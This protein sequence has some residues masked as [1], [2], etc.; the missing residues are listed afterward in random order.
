MTQSKNYLFLI[1]YYRAVG[2]YSNVNNMNIMKNRQPNLAKTVDTDKGTAS[3]RT[4]GPDFKFRNHD[5]SPTFHNQPHE[6][7]EKFETQ[8][9]TKAEREKAAGL[10]WIGDLP[11]LLFYHCK[12]KKWR[13]IEFSEESRY[14]GDLK[15]PSIIRLNKSD[16]IIL[17]GGCDNY[18]GEASESVFKANILHIESFKKINSMKNKRYGHCSAWIKDYLFVIGGFD[19]QDTETSSPSTLVACE[20]Y[21]DST[22]MWSDVANLIHPVSFASISA[23]KDE[24]LFVFGGFEDYT[25]VDIIQKYDF[26]SNSWDLLSIKLPVRLAKMGAT[27]IDNYNIIIAGG[28]YEDSSSETPLSLISNCYK[29]NLN[30]MSWGKAGKMKNKRTLNSS[31]F[32]YDNQIYAIG[33]SNKGA[34]EKYDPEAKIWINIP[35]YDSIL[36]NN[37]LQSFSVCMYDPTRLL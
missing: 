1:F 36:A 26:L 4:A 34:C 19:H 30:K 27:A 17:T 6:E 25:T 31:L 29:L 22:G 3:G 23:I 12:N 32:Q 24:Y 18:T 2:S 37:D 13:K 14:K 28:I 15:Y 5:P 20:K 8:V 7:E 9:V 11:F 10:Y 33:S 35:S 21:N 16:T